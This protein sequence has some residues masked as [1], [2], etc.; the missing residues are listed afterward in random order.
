MDLARA[1]AEH[2]PIRADAFALELVPDEHR[3]DAPSD[4]RATL[5]TLVWDD[6]DGERSLRDIREQTV[7]IVR[8]EHSDD[9]RVPAYFAGW[10]AAL[11]FVLERHAEL[12][13][14]GLRTEAL[15]QR[16]EY[17]LPMDLVFPGVLRLRRPQTADDFTAA[18][19]SGKKRLG[20]L[21][22]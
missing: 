15:R 22:P 20:R 12:A 19:L 11:R 2:L 14:A 8:R 5:R 6:R 13:A 1:F 18:L 21:L 3:G 17:S 9:P 7:V 4:L 16:L 10:A